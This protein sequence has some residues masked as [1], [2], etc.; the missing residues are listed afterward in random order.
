MKDWYYP[1]RTTNSA[2]EKSAWLREKHWVVEDNWSYA[3][4]NESRLRRS[5]RAL[6]H[7]NTTTI[8]TTNEEQ[9]QQ[10]TKRTIKVKEDQAIAHHRNHR[11]LLHDI[12]A[13]R[14]CVHALELARFIFLKG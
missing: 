7:G 8:T 10:Q 13:E 9:Q 1:K 11:K 12:G 4:A 2:P 3:I 6:L 5:S 14:K